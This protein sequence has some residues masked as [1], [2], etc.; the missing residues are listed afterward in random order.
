MV[1][2]DSA[3]I[4]LIVSIADYYNT[5][6][7]TRF[8]RPLLSN[9]L[10]ESDIARPL[11]DMTEHFGQFEAQGIHI[12]DLY[13]QLLAMSRFVYRVRVEVLPNLRS[14]SG[15]SLPN[16]PNKIYRDMAMNNFGANVQ[17]LASYLNE[18]YQRTVEFDRVR[19][20]RGKPYY[21]DMPA[22]NEVPRFLGFKK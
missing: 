2:R 7:A 11:A 18:L 5:N 10:A 9:V 19:N 6:I 1:I 21:Q 15:S 22:L 17:N 14:L 12:D 20:G 16:D 8:L 13:D 4:S 3:I